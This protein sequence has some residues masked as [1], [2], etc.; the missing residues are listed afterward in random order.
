M[1]AG[2]L[3]GIL[4]ASPSCVLPARAVVLEGRGESSCQVLA[5]GQPSLRRLQASVL[6]NRSGFSLKAAVS[7]RG[8]LG[9]KVALPTEDTG[10]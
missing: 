8:G 3:G 2:P 5:V 4:F 9:E 1:E 10:Q 7:R 6:S